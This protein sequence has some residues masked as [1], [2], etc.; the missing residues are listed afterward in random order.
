MTSS[1]PDQF[2]QLFHDLGLQLFERG[3]LSSNNILFNEMHA[4]PATVVDTGYATHAEQTVALIETGLR[5]AALGCIVNTHLHSDHCGGN[6]ALQRRWP[7]TTMI[8]KACR[9]AVSAWD[10]SQLSF[11]ATDQHCDRFTAETSLAPG[12]SLELGGRRW[13]VHAAPGHDPT[14]LMLFE[15]QSRVL[16]SGD[17]LW[18][19]RLAIVFPELVGEPGFEACLETLDRIERLAPTVVLPGH[20]PAFSEV[21]SA[22]S[23]SRKRVEA[24]RRSPQRHARHAARALVMFRMFEISHCSFDD[25]VSWLRRTPITRSAALSDS[26]WAEEIV[27]SL[28]ADGALHFDGGRLQAVR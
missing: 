11:A 26:Q 21:F 7:V 12:D 24:F 16:I 2:R 9:E 28:I 25:L 18:E 13:E 4:C 17:A 27:G 15:P 8:P 23:E 20:G 3:W 1:S 5:G 14:A 6:A 10:Q 22:L 19:R